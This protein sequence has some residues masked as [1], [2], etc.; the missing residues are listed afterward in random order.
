LI[1][2]ILYILNIYYYSFL[3]YYYKLKPKYTTE[4]LKILNC[5]D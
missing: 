5:I 4:L 1:V 3:N 2:N